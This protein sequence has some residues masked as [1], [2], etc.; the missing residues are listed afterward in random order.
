METNYTFTEKYNQLLN[1]YE[2]PKTSVSQN[3]DNYF[4]NKNGKEI[5]NI[6]KATPILKNW[7]DY[8]PPFLVVL[9]ESIELWYYDFTNIPKKSISITMLTYNEY[10]KCINKYKIK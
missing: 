4:F 5:G 7:F 9:S 10:K 3:E 6:P 8:K 1:V 2:Q